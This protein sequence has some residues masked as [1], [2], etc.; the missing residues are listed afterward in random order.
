V[1]L[2]AM[3][4][5]TG[6]T[7]PV[8]TD[9]GP[10]GDDTGAGHEPTRP[11]LVLVRATRDEAAGAALEVG[12]LTVLAR[13]LAQVSRLGRQAIVASD[14]SCPLPTP[15]P[16]GV[17][18]RPVVGP[19]EL[20]ALRAALGAPPEIGADV[21]R[22]ATRDL[23]NGL[24]VTDEATRRHAEDHVFG[25]LLRGDLG[26]VARYLNKPV[27][28]RITRYVLC[29][30]PITPNGVTLFAAAVG[31]AG[32]ALVASGAARLMLLGFLLAHVQSILDGCDG[33]LAR[34]RFQQ[35]ALGEWLDTVVDDALNLVL[36]AAV[37]VGVFRLTGEM[38]HLLLGAG[39]ALMLLVYNLVAYRELL[40][41]GEG[42]EVIK[43]RW[44]FTKGADLKTLYG[45]KR[46]PLSQLLSIGRRDFFLLA[47]LVF[48]AIG[49]LPL[50]PLYAFL[51]A[52]PEFVVALGQILWRLRGSPR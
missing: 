11:K 23:T 12:G 16:A 48:A 32:A 43:V 2:T 20:P 52:L 8:A 9:R 33:E 28:F 25:E 14:G 51:V 47:W 13:A 27:S 4:R 42:G 17:E 45:K 3:T 41:Q 19:E 36:F 15:R 6:S 46:G 24:R 30:L 10:R 31:L 5:G 1:A 29:R 40:R 22:P 26:L 18:V 38:R 34:V 7:T 49:L 39:G 44:W 21:V 37:G 50:V 35:S